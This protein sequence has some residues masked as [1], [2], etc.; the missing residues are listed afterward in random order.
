MCRS[1]L[2]GKKLNNNSKNDNCHNLKTLWLNFTIQL[3]R[4][5]NVV[6]SGFYM[7]SFWHVKNRS[8]LSFK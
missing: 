5:L 7:V 6:S 4:L 8:L 2:D 3:K 1:N